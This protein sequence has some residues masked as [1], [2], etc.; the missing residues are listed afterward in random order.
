MTMQAKNAPRRIYA[1]KGSILVLFE[2]LYFGP[3]NGEESKLTT[4]DTVTVE[5]LKKSGKLHRVQVTQVVD[6]GKSVVETWTEKKVV[7]EK[8][9]AKAA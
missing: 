5:T 4:D 2:G 6:G 9:A 7:F 3:K 1:R 8:R